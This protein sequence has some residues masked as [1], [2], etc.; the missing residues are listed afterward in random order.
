MNKKAF[1]GAIFTLS[2][3]FCGLSFTS[4]YAEEVVTSPIEFNDNI[5]ATSDESGIMPISDSSDITTPNDD[6]SDQTILEE[7]TSGEPEV[8]CAD[9]S[10][11][12]CED[13]NTTPE[14][15]EE[16]G[17][18]TEIEP[19]LWPLILSLSALGITI[20]FVIIINLCGRKKQK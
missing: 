13:T 4:A 14:I 15:V 7:G 11:P 16:D 8:V 19:E 2:L 20:V 17:E 1:F 10:E 9:A 6:V 5:E 3:M 18:R 12:G